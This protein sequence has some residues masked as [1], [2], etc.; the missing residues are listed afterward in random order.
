MIE[1]RI[2]II[3][4][5]VRSTSES[6]QGFKNIIPDEAVAKSGTDTW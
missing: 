1:N 3:Y 6:E 2:F 5:H 4:H